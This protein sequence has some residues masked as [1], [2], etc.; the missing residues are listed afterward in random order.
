MVPEVNDHAGS[1]AWP[2]LQNQRVASA[3]QPRTPTVS[4]G[5]ELPRHDALG[6]TVRSAEGRESSVAPPRLLD[7]APRQSTSV[8]QQSAPVDLLVAEAAAELST[9]AEDTGR[10]N[11]NTLAALLADCHTRMAARNTHTIDT[12]LWRKLSQLQTHLGLMASEHA[13]SS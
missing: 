3:Q 12:N 7:A 1:A 10:A 5:I 4:W 11:T 6:S 2:E 8:D 9:R 13:D